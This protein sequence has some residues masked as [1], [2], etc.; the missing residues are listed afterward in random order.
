MVLATYDG[1]T[2]PSMISLDAIDI[3]IKIHDLPDEFYPMVKFLVR[4]VGEF[5]YAE[6]NSHDFKGNFYCVCVK[7]NLHNL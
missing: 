1:F 4:K 5:I 3:W 6:P 2:K 7:I